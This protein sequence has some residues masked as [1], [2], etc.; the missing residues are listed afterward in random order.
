[1]QQKRDLAN[2]FVR[3]I[4][5]RRRS[6]V[7]HRL[8]AWFAAFDL[9]YS[10]ILIDWSIELFISFRRSLGIFV[11]QHEEKRNFFHFRERFWPS[12]PL[13][14]R[15]TPTEPIPTARHGRS[16]AHKIKYSPTCCAF[17]TSKVPRPW[18][19]SVWLIS[20]PASSLTAVSSDD[21]NWS[22]FPRSCPRRATGCCNSRRICACSM[23]RLCCTSKSG[24]TTWTRC[25]WFTRRTTCTR[26]TCGIFG[27]PMWCRIRLLGLRHRPRGLCDWVVSSLCPECWNRRAVA[28]SARTKIN[29]RYVTESEC[30][31]TDWLIEWLSDWLIDWLIGWLIIRSIDWLIGWSILGWLIDWPICA[32]H[33][34]TVTRAIVRKKMQMC[35]QWRSIGTEKSNSKSDRIRRKTFW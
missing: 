23:C 1:M 33:S 19:W 8:I 22:N 16:A 6:N 34:S 2:F 3:L 7:L 5:A 29:S 9:I 28:T 21:P 32:L 14:W 20:Y 17:S 24:P 27:W 11:F 18:R 25:G 26:I 31:L 15:W 35:H 13:P 4:L 30:R 10:L 12:K